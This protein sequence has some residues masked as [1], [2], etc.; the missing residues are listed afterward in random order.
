MRLSLLLLFTFLNIFPSTAQ[1]EGCVKGDCYNGFGVWEWKSGSTYMG[2]FKD[3][4]RHG[5]GYFLFKNGDKYIGNWDKN[6]REGYGVYY[7]HKKGAFKQY[8]GEW[9]EDQ[10]SGVGVMVYTN[11]K[12]KFG[13]WANNKYVQKYDSLGCQKGDCYSE[14]SLYVWED[15]SRYE[16]AY[17]DG[18]RH[19]KGVY[20]HKSG[21]KYTGQQKY[22]RREGFGTY[23]Y[24]SGNKYQGYWD[25]E[26][27]HGEGTLYSE[28]KILKEGTWVKGEFTKETLIK[29]KKTSPIPPKITEKGLPNEPELSD[30]V[31]A[32]K[33]LPNI[34]LKFPATNKYVTQSDNITI[35]LKMKG[36]HDTDEVQVKVN[37]KSIKDFQLLGDGRFYLKTKLAEHINLIEVIITNEAGIYKEMLAIVKDDPKQ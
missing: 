14:P 30:N 2:S 13:I 37:A 1:K 25:A 8:S 27:K 36:V 28:G 9:L 24:I 26:V 29:P 18:K 7:Y 16:G 34:Q 32:V 11:G 15:G 17:E 19:G 33:T 31:K 35:K 5:Y 3:G 22:G 6:I 20:Y 10:R 23:Y 12:T 21:S 4:N